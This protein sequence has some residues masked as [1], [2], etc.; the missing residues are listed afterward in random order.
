MTSSKTPSQCDCKTS[1]SCCK[2]DAVTTIDARGQIVLPKAIR[3]K[4][5]YNAGDKLAIITL[6]RD[7][8]PCCLY[9]IGAD[10]LSDPIKGLLEPMMK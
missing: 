10:M 3:E 6:E 9:M 7:G 2:I 4:M 5:G 8:K 1:G